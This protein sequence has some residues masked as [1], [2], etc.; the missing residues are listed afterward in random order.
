MAATRSFAVGRLLATVA[1]LAGVAS[2]AADAGVVWAL[3]SGQASVESPGGTGGLLVRVVWALIRAIGLL[4]V[5]RHLARG[6]AL[7]RGVAVVLCVTTL[8]NAV[9]LVGTRAE[10]LDGPVPALAVVGALVTAAALCVGLLVL[11]LAVPAVRAHLAPRPTDRRRWWAPAPDEPAWVLT[12]RPLAASLLPCMVVPLLIGAAALFGG[13]IA[14][15]Y[16][17]GRVV[18]AGVAL[19]VQLGLVLLFASTLGYIL[20]G[21]GRVRGVRWVLAGYAFVVL[22]TQPAVCWAAL[23][24]D[25]LV[26]DALPMVIAAALVV[27]GVL[28]DRRA[29]A[30]FAAGGRRG[31]VA[32]HPG[33]PGGTERGPQISGARA[34]GA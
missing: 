26:R 32:G 10:V 13:D 24:V 34:S 3:A 8:F 11:L 27:H 30:W 18:A 25:G 22:A 23:G 6:S 14:E 7:A 2:L 29:R 5:A 1:V 31:R 15:R 33:A 19:V 17:S 9:R 4:L 28:G 20:L 12:A 16:G 21:L